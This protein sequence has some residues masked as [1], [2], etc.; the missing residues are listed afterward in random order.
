[1]VKKAFFNFIDIGSWNIHGLFDNINGNKICEIYEPEFM[2][3]FKTIDFSVYR[4]PRLLSISRHKMK[5]F[6]RPIRGNHRYF[7]VSCSGIRII[8]EREFP[9]LPTSIMTNYGLN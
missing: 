9:L 5:H 8:S 3:I 7:G 4:K 1:M 6:N 2:T